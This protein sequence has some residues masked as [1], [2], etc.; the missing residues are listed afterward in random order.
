MAFRDNAVAGRGPVG[1]ST[2]VPFL[3]TLE[4]ENAT[5][6]STRSYRS[7]STPFRPLTRSLVSPAIGFA[8]MLGCCV[9]WASVFARPASFD[10]PAAA[11]Q[12]KAPARTVLVQRRPQPELAKGKM[13]VAAEGLPDPNFGESVVLLLEDDET[14][15]MGLVINRDTGVR[16][17]E[18]LPD[19]KGLD[20]TDATIFEGGPVERH[21]ILVLVRASS[22]PD[23]AQLVFEDIY[24]SG[25][26]DLLKSLVSE[27]AKDQDFRAFSGYAGWGPGQLEAEIREGAWFVF[28]GNRR[29]VFDPRPGNV[30]QEFIRRTTLQLAGVSLIGWVGACP[31]S[32][33][34]AF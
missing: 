25:S 26:A 31:C 2:S 24:V 11:L 13:L 9:W 10:P 30:W 4:D 27:S 3:D 21:K 28:P 18:I 34:W 1:L 22:P 19:L 5:M 32:Q 12:N 8:A 20:S 29:A 23:E 14:S 16:L 7:M 15:T 17:S 6:G 33:T